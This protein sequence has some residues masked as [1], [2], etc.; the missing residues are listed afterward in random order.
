MNDHEAVLTP[1]WRYASVAIA[2]HWMLAVGVFGLMG[3]G[4]YMLS[5]E[6]DPGSAW[7]FD[8]HK[9]FGMIV[10]VLVLA[11]IW[12]RARH[13]PAPLPD[14]VPTWQVRLAHLTQWGLYG[15]LV[16]MPILGFIGASYSEEGVTFF[17]L[18][19]PSWLA[20]NHDRS[21]LLFSLHI[22][23]AWVLGALIALHVAGALKHLLVDRDGVF[24]RM[25]PRW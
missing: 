2:L 25:W 10:F 9:S 17:D 18:P 14:S 1:P 19:L 7:Y 23:L 20:Q 5:I 3:V 4:W 8:K 6:K 22:G 11:R 24:Q 12:W 21:E 15:C 13:R 16:L